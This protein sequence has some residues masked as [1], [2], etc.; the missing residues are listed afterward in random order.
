MFGYG[1][2]FA[3]L[4]KTGV[5]GDYDGHAGDSLAQKLFSICLT[6]GLVS[7]LPEGLMSLLITDNRLLMQTDMVSESMAEEW[8]AVRLI[9][10]EVWSLWSGYVDVSASELR[11]RVLRGFMISWHYI[12]NRVLSQLQELPFCLAVGDLDANVASLQSLESPPSERATS[13]LWLLHKA[14]VSGSELKKCLELLRNVS[15]T[16]HMVERLHASCASMRK[17]HPDYS[18]NTLLGRSFLHAFRHCYGTDV[19]ADDGMQGIRK[20]LSKLRQRQTSRLT[21]RQVFFAEMVL[22][23]NLLPQL[24]AA[25]EADN[26]EDNA[27]PWQTLAAAAATQEGA[28]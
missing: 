15:L 25:P 17:R 3:F 5:L 26:G 1:H 12:D 14:G 6:L 27:Q 18:K 4:R 24:R 8:E 9:P 10:R 7:F 19:R 23:A 16:S 11:D 20:R 28:L 13:Q 22:K 21:G 2:C